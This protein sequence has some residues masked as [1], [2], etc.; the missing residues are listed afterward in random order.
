M[1]ATNSRTG[2]RVARRSIV[3]AVVSAAVVAL[4]AG[5]WAA[6]AVGDGERF[7][8]RGEIVRVELSADG[9]PAT[10]T[11][12]V[13]PATG[14]WRAEQDGRTEIYTGDAY[15]LLDGPRGYLRQGSPAF[16]GS[17]K[18]GSVSL[19]PLRAFLTGRAFDRADSSGAGS[20]NVLRFVRNGA[21]IEGLIDGKLAQP[22]AARLELFAVPAD[23]I[24][25]IA[26]ERQPGA[27]PSIGVRAYWFGPSTV[28]HRA[29]NAV[30]HTTV[31]G[32]EL[33][34]LGSTP[35]DEAQ[36]Y[37]TFYERGENAGRSSAYP[38]VAPN[39][40]IQVSN[41]PISS[42]RAQGAIDAAN[43]INGDLRYA[44]WPRT[45]IRLRGGENAIVIPDAGESV[46]PTRNGFLVLTPTTLVKVTGG[47]FAL[48][49][50]PKLAE[51]LV[52]VGG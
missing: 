42:A 1:A 29:V 10:R 19:A 26:R 51:T 24:T 28:E 27:P 46:G 13:D 2:R 17:L 44:P 31:V 43:G 23:R 22:E 7:V 4:A 14:R 48:D 18:T 33:R 34:R 5:G 12:W 37:I 3:V 49:D 41:E 9:A 52:L 38:G 30:E 6:T 35:R 50:I 16:L 11:E 32:P 45:K 47:P 15:V 40:E 21:A 36:L 25:T 39:G 8:Q 20:G